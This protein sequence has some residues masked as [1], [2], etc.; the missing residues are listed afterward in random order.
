MTVRVG[1][2]GANG[3]SGLEL[4]RLLKHHPHVQVEMLM[5]HST[6]GKSIT[7]IAPHLKGICELPLE[8]VSIEEASKRLDC[9]FFATPAGV[10]GSLA[11]AFMDA[12]VSCIDLSGDFR[13]QDGA[14]YEK[15]YKKTSA[16][17][18][19]LNQAVYGLPELNRERIK[20]TQLVAN[21]GCYP[22]ATLLGLIPALQ[23]GFIDPNHIVIDGKS[24]VSGAGR[25]PVLS[26]H[27]GEVNETVSAYKIG[28]HQ[29]IPEIEQTIEQV[30]GR[31]VPV[32]FTTHLIP[33][34]RGLMCTI[35]ATLTEAVDTG[36][37][38]HAYKQYYESHPFVRIQEE[39]IYP[40]TKQVL[41]SNYCDIGLYCDER[42][43]R[44]T[45]VSVI[46]NVVK[47]AAGQAIQNMN[48]IYGW[49]ETTG[50]EWTPLFP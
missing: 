33:M 31:Y 21:P 3:Y 22:T 35:Y 17:D 15:W 37:V 23:T 48:L 10:S 40:T 29:H 49:E 34:T 11:P 1:I 19:W 32:S 24:G 39:G 2:I 9:L 30:I 7:E 5:S 14:L 50:L 38:I 47:G 28:S 36:T 20:E 13:L 26:S 45:I 25:K 42:T 4:I 27:F 44:M 6:E 41:G 43:H 16:D 8:K 18:S 46:D 12:G